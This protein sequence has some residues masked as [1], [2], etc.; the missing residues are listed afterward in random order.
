MP[1]KRPAVTPRRHAPPKAVPKAAPA[2]VAPKRP[3]GRPR[4][5]VQAGDAVTDYQRMTLRLPPATF[6]QLDAIALKLNRPRWYVV[7][8]ALKEYIARYGS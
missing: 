1:K 6:A 3:R 8:A 2:P 5:G 7:F 4:T